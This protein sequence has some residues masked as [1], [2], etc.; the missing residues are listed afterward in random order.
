MTLSTE[1]MNAIALRILSPR[2][3]YRFGTWP[4]NHQ[5][6]GV[7]SEC[8]VKIYGSS[9]GNLRPLCSK[10][11]PRNLVGGRRLVLHPNAG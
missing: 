3:V 1:W 8:F 2:N 6:S 5:P 9:A 4:K 7:A 10:S 11:L